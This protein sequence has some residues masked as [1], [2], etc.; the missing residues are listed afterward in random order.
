MGKVSTRFAP[1]GGSSAMNCSPPSDGY[2]GGSNLTTDKHA[3]QQFIIDYRGKGQWRLVDGLPRL[4]T[5]AFGMPQKLVKH[6]GKTRFYGCD[7]YATHLTV[8]AG[9]LPWEYLDGIHAGMQPTTK[10]RAI[11][12]QQ[13]GIVRYYEVPLGYLTSVE[14]VVFTYQGIAYPSGT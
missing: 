13:A 10:K 6:V 2:S 7:E 12:L 3:S 4:V 1:R 14:T 11:E 8:D 9:D 5:V